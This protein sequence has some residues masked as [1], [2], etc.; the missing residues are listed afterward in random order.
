MQRKDKVFCN[1]KKIFLWIEEVGVEEIGNVARML[2]GTGCGA[3]GVE[4][5]GMGIVGHGL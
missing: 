3:C 1:R 4:G 5:G 2:E